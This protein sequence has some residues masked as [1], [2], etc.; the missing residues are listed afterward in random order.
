MSEGFKDRRITEPNLHDGLLRSLTVREGD[1][2][3]RCSDV[4]GHDVTLWLLGVVHLK[5]DNFRLGNIIFGIETFV[6]NDCPETLVRDAAGL[7]E[8]EKRDWLTR[9]VE[10]IAA[11]KWT[12]IRIGASYGCEVV[13]V[14]KAW[15]FEHQPLTAP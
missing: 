12:G 13:A 7:L 14:A 1:L 4:A 10:R 2:E 5:A 6:G 8:G 15:R 3:I 9:E 11:A